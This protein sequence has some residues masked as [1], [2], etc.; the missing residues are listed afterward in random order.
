MDKNKKGLKGASSASGVGSS[1][2][3]AAR[4]VELLTEGADA[5]NGAVIHQRAF[6]A[7]QQSA[8]ALVSQQM[9]ANIA[10]LQ[11]QQHEH[12]AAAAISE[13]KLAE[14]KAQYQADMAA[15]R[16][17]RASEA[18]QH[19][20]AL[21]QA[22]QVQEAKLAKQEKEWAAEELRHQSVLQKA[23]S[24]HADEC[25]AMDR[26]RAAKELHYQQALQQEE[27][28]AKERLAR[29][30][31]VHTTGIVEREKEFGAACAEKGERLNTL[32]EEETMIQERVAAM[33]HA[34]STNLAKA[35]I[36]L[37]VSGEPFASTWCNLTRFPRSL[38]FE[39]LR[40]YM[41]EHG[42]DREAPLFIDGS[43]RHFELVLDYLR[44]PEH[45]PFCQDR[46]Q[47]QWLERQAAFY[48]LVELVG[49]CQD[50][51]CRLQR[52]EVAQL[53]NGK[54]NLSSMD[55]RK[56]NLSGLDFSGASLH[57]A[58]LSG[59]SLDDASLSGADTKLTSA[60]LTGAHASRACFDSCTATKIDL[61]K[62]TLLDASFAS[63][64]LDQG[65]FVSCSAVGASFKGASATAADFTEADL[66]GADLKG[67]DFEGA[68][69][70]GAI[71]KDA[72][73]LTAA[74]IATL[75]QKSLRG[76]NLSGLDMS[77]FNLIKVDLSNA[78]LEG[79]DLTG[80][81]LEGANLTGANVTGAKMQRAKLTGSKGLTSAM[82]ATLDQQS[83]SG[84]NLAGLDMAGFGLSG[85]DLSNA[86]LEGA[87]L[88][89]ANLTG[90]K[91]KG[92][93][94][95]ACKGL[96]ALADTLQKQ[97]VR[98][99]INVTGSSECPHVNGRYL[100]RNA[101]INGYPSYAHKDNSSSS[102]TK[103][104]LKKHSTHAIWLFAGGIDSE[105]GW[106]KASGTGAANGPVALPPSAWE[107]WNGKICVSKSLTLEYFTDSES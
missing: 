43:S 88:T 28:A 45:L 57:R 4:L 17:Q 26:E 47:V 97:G 67:A 27:A 64:I 55:L 51:C 86:N 63:A 89:G 54:G 19:Q 34:G 13:K 44:S 87:D 25:A 11:K 72:K 21:K 40:Q 79:A 73:G 98:V 35:P 75:D 74:M 7:E 52:V 37:M 65:L 33:A 16:K 78:N 85:I 8:A 100:S 106:A 94:L 93:K 30:Q 22:T 76:A 39:L 3:D 38:F 107:E 5:A 104:F 90:A 82:I 6:L 10:R 77:G 1:H 53:L 50:E 36:K 68:N 32:A 24:D 56:V 62:A 105:I 99:G 41:E 31:E 91:I 60:A 12:D 81:N 2:A 58:Q 69:L 70:T 83:L 49:K 46:A 102:R 96:T 18:L 59:A 9:D 80:A 95:K 101:D 14:M 61:S 103:V 42:D 48:N 20:E 15:G 29:I 71:L 92:I 84:A 66:T 23:S